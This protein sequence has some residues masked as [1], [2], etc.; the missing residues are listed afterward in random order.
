MKNSLF[1]A[2]IAMATL[3]F[4]I[5]NCNTTSGKIEKR[6]SPAIDMNREWHIDIIDDNEVNFI[7]DSDTLKIS[8]E[9]TE[10]LQDINPIAFI[11]N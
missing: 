11:N 1:I 9:S 3:G 10:G 5:T 6:K 7:S 4:T 2:M 8:L